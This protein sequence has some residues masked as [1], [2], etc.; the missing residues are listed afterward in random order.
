MFFINKNEIG[1][2][3]GNIKLV[4]KITTQQSS[5]YQDFHSKMQFIQNR[6]MMMI[7]II[8]IIFIFVI[9]LS[10]VLTNLEFIKKNN[11]Q[12]RITTK[13]RMYVTQ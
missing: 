9:I 10:D 5:N 11:K 7:I 3:F 1:S 6:I 12:K 2:I 4:R 13:I 8:I